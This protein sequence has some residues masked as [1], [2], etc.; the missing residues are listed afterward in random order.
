MSE[1]SY[2]KADS[3]D[4]QERK[5]I[6]YDFLKSDDTGY[7]A[8]TKSMLM[9]RKTRLMVNLNDLRDFRKT[10]LDMNEVVNSFIKRPI[11]YINPWHSALSEFAMS[12]L[13][14][15][16]ESSAITSSIEKDKTKSLEGRFTIGTEGSFGGNRV[17]PRDL[18]SRRLG[19]LVCVEGIATKCTRVRPKV[20]KTVH[21]CERTGAYMER[22]FYD[23]TSRLVAPATGSAYPT[24]TDQGDPLITEFGYSTYTDSQTLAIQEMPEKS[25]AGLLPMSIDVILEGDVCDSCKPGDRIRVSGVYMALSNSGN[26]GEVSGFRTVLIANAVSPLIKQDEVVRY[27]GSKGEMGFDH[28][29]PVQMSKYLNV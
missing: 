15:M 14:N 6:F 20:N 5:R 24:K 16:D 2:Y 25:P 28:G 22:S 19:Q 8:K 7:T 13:D 18:N 12:L 17:T 9:E 3:A 21:Y 10:G 11:D 1:K 4:F 26:S 27:G 29:L 23:H